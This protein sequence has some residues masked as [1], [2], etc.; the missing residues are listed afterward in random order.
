M[1]GS[2]P[3]VVG[4][5]A[6]G[7][8]TR[9]LAL[10][11]EEREITRRSGP[12]GAVDP[13]DPDA[14]V[15]VIGAL[16]HDMEADGEIEL[17]V[18]SL[19]AGVAGAG[20]TGIRKQVGEALTARNL[21][22]RVR[23]LTDGEVALFDAHGECPGLLLV[24]G[25]G[26]VA[27]GRNGRGEVARAGGWGPLLG[28]EGSGYAVARAALRRT[29]RAADGREEASCL[30]PHLLDRLGLEDVGELVG[31]IAA[32]PRA[33]VASLAPTVVEL[34]DDGVPPAVV[35]VEDAVKELAEAVLAVRRR[36]EPWKTPPVLALTGGL[37]DPDGPLRS[38]M[39]VRAERLDIEVR[40][41]PVDPVRGAARLATRVGRGS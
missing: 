24:S 19:C 6:G 14:T 26:S 4:I 21:A 18:D 17:P 3:V 41:E 37:L 39:A 30:A 32:A 27:W 7:S 9:A 10:D 13:R 34:A 35:I 16:L 22:R 23:V 5:D 28:D 40:D 2:P 20:R 38:R 29:T 33:E 12:P 36:L 25:T 31:W 11:G 1:K 15:T 8:R